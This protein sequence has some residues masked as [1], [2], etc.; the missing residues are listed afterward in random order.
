MDR[1]DCYE[2][3]HESLMNIIERNLAK[4]L[5][6][7]KPPVNTVHSRFIASCLLEDFQNCLGHI[8]VDD[9]LCALTGWIFFEIMDIKPNFESMSSD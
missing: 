5:L 8:L 9:G 4:E 1:S 7:D 2:F 6:G 3:S